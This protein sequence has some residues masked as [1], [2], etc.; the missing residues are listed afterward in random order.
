MV[1]QQYMLYTTNIAPNYHMR[2]DIKKALL[3]VFSPLCFLMP[4]M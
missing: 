1:N 4:V 2:P 3:F